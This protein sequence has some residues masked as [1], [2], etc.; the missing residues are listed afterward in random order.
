MTEVLETLRAAGELPYEIPVGGSSG[1][2]VLGYAFGTRELVDQLSELGEQPTRLY[3][4]S[5]S[6]GTAEG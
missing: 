1:V 3:F 4:A 5:G 6:R 2:G